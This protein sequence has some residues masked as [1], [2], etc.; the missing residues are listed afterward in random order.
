MTRKKKVFSGKGNV[1]SSNFQTPI[2]DRTGRQI[3]G[4]QAINA[5]V[6]RRRAEWRENH[7]GREPLAGFSYGSMFPNIQQAPIYDRTGRQITGQQAINAEV[8]R[9]RAE[10]REWKEQGMLENQE[11]IIYEDDNGS[12]TVVSQ[13]YISPS[14]VIDNNER[15][16]EV[17]ESGTYHSHSQSEGE[18]SNSYS[19]SSSQETQQELFTQHQLTPYKKY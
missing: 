9:R 15:F 5:E 6:E 3:T 18:R 10:W 7:G 8:E 11:Q 19:G 16:M 13:S 4:Q 1:F 12:R 17:E 14:L 2:Y